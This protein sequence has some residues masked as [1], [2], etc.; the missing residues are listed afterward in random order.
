MLVFVFQLY[1]R[2]KLALSLQKQITCLRILICNLVGANQALRSVPLGF[3]VPLLIGS[4][5]ASLVITYNLTHSH[6]RGQCFVFV[7][8]VLLLLYHALYIG[9]AL[10]V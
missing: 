9:F 10:V 1:L 6:H 4:G 7:F 8:F 5:Q 3:L 2:L